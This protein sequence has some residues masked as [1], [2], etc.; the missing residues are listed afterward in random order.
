M[1][2][3]IIYTIAIISIVVV[4]IYPYKNNFNNEVENELEHFL[5]NY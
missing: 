4:F 3:A 1:I 2:N 5:N